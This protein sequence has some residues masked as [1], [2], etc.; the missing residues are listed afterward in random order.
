MKQLP[1]EFFDRDTVA[2]ARELVG[3]IL[4]V[5][6]RRARILEVEA[7]KQDRA[8]H[9][10]TLTERSRIMHE[11]HGHVYV[12]LVYGM[13]YC[14]NITTDSKPGAVLIRGLDC[15]GCGGPG[16]LCRELGI[17]AADNGLRL[18][19]RFRVFD[20]GSRPRVK[21]SGRIG[22]REDTHLRWRFY[23]EGGGK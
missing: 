20:D 18:G 8:S 7:Y 1:M 17:T 14:L 4:Q 5:G 21:S 6:R 16:K 10:R 12:Y 9:A 3:K 2:V 19:K 22:I 15:E 11:T 23:A 13:Y